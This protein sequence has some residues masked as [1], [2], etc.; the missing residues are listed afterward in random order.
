M[1]HVKKFSWNEKDREA[2][3]SYVIERGK[4]GSERHV[5]ECADAPKPE[6]LEALQALAVPALKECEV[7]RVP[8]HDL[9]ASMEKI[10]GPEAVEEHRALLRRFSEAEAEATVRS[11]SFSWS[12]DIMGA[13]ICLL[14]ALDHADQTLVLNTPHKPSQP[15]SGE[16]GHTLPEGMVEKLERLH[17]LV[18]RYIDG[19]R[20]RQ[21]TDLFEDQDSPKDNGCTLSVNGGP[22]VPL[23]TVRRALA[24]IKGK[25]P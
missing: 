1:V 24:V 10:L 8:D 21:Q 9:F 19:D 7:I 2:S 15:Y 16:T 18:E 3:V 12:L 13:S 5:L 14:V 23:A 25:K 20:V 11:V 22:H 6:L 17:V 4:D